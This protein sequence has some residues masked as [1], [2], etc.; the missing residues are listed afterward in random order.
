MYWWASPFVLLSLFLTTPTVT[1]TRSSRTDAQHCSS[2]VRARQFRC[3][4]VPLLQKQLTSRRVRIRGGGSD[5]IACEG[6]CGTPTLQPGRNVQAG[7]TQVVTP[8]TTESSSL[9]ATFR[10]RVL[11]WSTPF[12]VGLFVYATFHHV[13]WLFHT[14]VQS[15]SMNTWL[16]ETLDEVNLQA[17]VVT[18][19]VNGPVVTSISV[20]LATLLTMT[21]S[22]LHAR[23]IDI[24]KSYILEM[25]AIRQLQLL[26]SSR[27]AHQLLNT[28]DRDRIAQLVVGHVDRFNTPRALTSFR[29]KRKL[30]SVVLTTTPSDSATDDAHEYIESNLLKLLDGLNEIMLSN[31]A[32]GLDNRESS[33]QQLLLQMRS[34]SLRLI[35]ERSNRWLAMEGLHFPVVHYLTLSLLALSILCAFLVA[36]DEAEF[37]FLRGLPIRI[38]W[39]LLCTCLASLAVLCYDLG[40]PFGGAYRVGQ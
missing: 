2:S 16:P 39:T 32:Q 37:I 34:L 9:D 3:R 26:I 30:K 22:N 4:S 15:M 33:I 36:T 21:M 5:V 7:D 10:Y 28:T 31:H 11:L 25:Q 14:T 6:P 38:L 20:I 17:N 8:R 29:G 23:Q 13:T 24:Q 35:Q 18:Q 1:S 27:T 12:L 40:L 19:V